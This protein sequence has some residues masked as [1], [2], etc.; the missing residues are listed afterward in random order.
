MS[1]KPIAKWPEPLGDVRWQTFSPFSSH[2]VILRSVAVDVSHFVRFISTATTALTRYCQSKGHMGMLWEL[3]WKDKPLRCRRGHV[4]GV[5]G[6]LHCSVGWKILIWK[7]VLYGTFKD[8]KKRINPLT[9]NYYPVL[10]VGDTRTFLQ[11]LV[12]GWTLKKIYKK[13]YPHPQVN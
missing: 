2:S 13:A 4:W 1:I 9:I 12:E 3:C 8:K 5:P 6:R 7:C 11:L 10:R